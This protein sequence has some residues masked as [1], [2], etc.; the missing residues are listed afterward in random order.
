MCSHD[1]LSNLAKAAALDGVNR[2]LKLMLNA[3]PFVLYHHPLKQ[4]SLQSHR[5][6][7]QG[8]AI[9]ALMELCEICLWKLLFA[10][11]FL[12]KKHGGRIICNW[13]L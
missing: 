13:I 9:R 2:Q 6:P 1:V 3:E 10:L 8:S 7:E 11:K 4:S 12:H 5:W